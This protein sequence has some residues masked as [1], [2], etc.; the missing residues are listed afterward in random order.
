MTIENRLNNLSP[1]ILTAFSPDFVFL[2]TPE[3]VQHFPARDWKKE[4]YQQALTEKLGTYALQAWQNKVV[5]VSDE[6]ELL[7]ILPK[8]HDTQALK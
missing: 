8:F 1:A 4:Q 5:A 6:K 2:V 7:A 3:K